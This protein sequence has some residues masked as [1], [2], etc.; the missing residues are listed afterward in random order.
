MT[1]TNLPWW[2]AY[3]AGNAAAIRS[4]LGAVGVFFLVL[5]IAGAADATSPSQNRAVALAFFLALGLFALT[6]LLPSGLTAIR[7]Y[8][9]FK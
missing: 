9:G 3:Y 1:E 6:A 7:M 2:L 4:C 8:Q 5:S